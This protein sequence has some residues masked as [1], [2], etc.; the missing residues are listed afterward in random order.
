MGIFTTR[1]ANGGISKRI[2]SL[3]GAIN[4]S[5]GATAAQDLR[6]RN[7]TFYNVAPFAVPFDGVIFQSVLSN[8]TTNNYTIE[9]LVN[10][11]VVTSFTRTNGTPSEI[12]DLGTPISVAKNDQI[13]LRY[14]GGVGTT[15]RPAA[16]L[17]IREI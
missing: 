11:T 15:N 4:A 16:Q 2:L 17:Y 1:N 14:A 9:V 10:N 13:R 7:G 5:V 8:S 6:D 12:F 3:D